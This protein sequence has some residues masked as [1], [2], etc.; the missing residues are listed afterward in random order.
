ML[1]ATDTEYAPWYIV[2]SD[3]KKRAR[4]NCIFHLLNAIPYEK[5]PRKKVRLPK[6]S[7]HGRY[8]DFATIQDRRFVAERY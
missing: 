8:D 4:L 2:R 3:D 1:A 5:V 7:H 6:R